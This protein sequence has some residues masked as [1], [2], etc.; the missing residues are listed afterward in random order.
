MRM[1]LSFFSKSYFFFFAN[2]K[3]FSRYLTLF[4]SNYILKI[5]LFVFQ[6]S[7]KQ[8]QKNGLQI[9]IRSTYVL[10]FYKL[11]NEFWFFNFY[12]RLWIV[13][14]SVTMKFLVQNISKIFSLLIY[15]SICIYFYEKALQ[16]RLQSI[17]F[18][19]GFKIC[20][21]IIKS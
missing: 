3:Y 6:K 8:M 5:I 18:Y 19:S 14:H 7:F 17:C 21:F 12:L 13:V 11:L 16:C 2:L 10:F 4:Q 15:D 9:I 20:T 1:Q